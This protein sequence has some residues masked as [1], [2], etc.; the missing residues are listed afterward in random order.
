MFYF[1]P[2]PSRTLGNV[3]SINKSH[4]MS[5]FSCK[6]IDPDQYK[7]GRRCRRR[8]ICG[9]SECVCAWAV[10]ALSAYRVDY[11][12]FI[13]SLITVHE[14]AVTL[15]RMPVAYDISYN[16]SCV[17]AKTKILFLD[18]FEGN[19]VL[20]Q[21]IHLHENNNTIYRQFKKYLNTYT[22]NA[23][24]YLYYAF[25]NHIIILFMVSKR[26]EKVVKINNSGKQ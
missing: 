14:R 12:I 5:C 11:V 2:V 15:N 22:W 6:T 24:R 8:W 17:K 21:Q 4:F 20:D 10:M 3:L 25:T 18:L 19:S 26:D 9:G 1:A 13:T 23:L 7:R 16:E